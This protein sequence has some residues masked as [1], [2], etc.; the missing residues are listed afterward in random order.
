MRICDLQLGPPPGRV[1][2]A[3]RMD[4]ATGQLRAE[5]AAWWEADAEQEAQQ[6]STTRV[7]DLVL[8]DADRP[9]SLAA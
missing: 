5:L 1:R 3:N 9:S 4:E 2:L 8:D 7:Q 6:T